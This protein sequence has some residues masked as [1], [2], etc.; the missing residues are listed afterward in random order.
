[1]KSENE[2]LQRSETET[3]QT[4][5]LTVTLLETGT[6]TT[7]TKLLRLAPP[8]IRHKESPIVTDKDILHLLLRLLVHVLLVESHESLGDTLTD[9]VDLGSVTTTLDTDPHVDASE[10]VLAEEKDWL[11]DLETE[12]LWVEQLDRG[13]VELDHTATR[14][15]VGYSHCCLLTPEALNGLLSRLSRHG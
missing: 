3:K 6:S 4:I 15:A 5:F 10:T 1:M 13:A 7:P 14:L 9:G 2:T 12:D 11:E 8:R